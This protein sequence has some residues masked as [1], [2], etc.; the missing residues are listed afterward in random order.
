MSDSNSPNHR[1]FGR[2]EFVLYACK[3]FAWSASWYALKVNM[4]TGIAAPVS[5]TWRFAIA[6]ILMFVW[7]KFSGSPLWFPW[8]RQVQFAAL[9]VLLFSTNFILFYIASQYVVSGLLAVVFSLASVINLGIAALRGESS[10]AIRWL[11]AALGVS[12]IALLYLPELD[13]GDTA[14]TGLVLCIGGTLCFC[15]GNMLSQTLQ[16]EQVSV[17]SASAWGMS[18]GAVWSACLATAFACEF[19]FDVSIEYIASLL[20]LVT[21]A[22]LLAFWAFLNLIGRIGPGRAAYATVMFPIGALLLS[23]LIENWQ[24]TSEALLGV[25]LALLGN[26]LVLRGGARS[27]P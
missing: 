21:V 1:A 24:W 16:K 17:L 22:T 18:W 11:G 7:A 23:T 4:S 26:V 5:T 15:L 19:E 10:P 12:G 14:L 20:F 9:G 27:R 8:K 6:A 25:M 2:R 13:N 3:V